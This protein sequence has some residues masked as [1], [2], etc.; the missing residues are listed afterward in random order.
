M[1]RRQDL[2]V[3]FFNFIGYSK[4][5]LRLFRYRQKPVTRII[6]FHDIQDDT[7]KNF[8]DKM[9]VL[10]QCTN[11]VNLKDYLAGRL[12][13]E[14]LNIV[15]TFDDGYKGWIKYAIPV[16]KEMGFPATFFVTSGF[17]GLTKKCESEFVEKNLFRTSKLR[18]ISGGLSQD[19][20]R[21]IIREGFLL[22]GHTLSHC[23]L[24]SISEAEKVKHEIAEDKLKL[25]QISGKKVDYF[26]Y[27]MGGYNNPRLDLVK[28]LEELGF[29]AAVTTVPGFN[30]QGS[31]PYLLHRDLTDVSMPTPVFSARIAG[32]Y[33]AIGFIKKL[34]H[35]D[36]RKLGGYGEN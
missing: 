26:A 12:S 9:V 29:K 35:Y 27:P 36:I 4:V 25:E 34:L 24:E 5:R 21:L 13:F 22:G 19:D 14:K 20:L 30:I 28:S 8:R 31:N 33:D 15:I 32:N 23:D 16:L 7:S 2:L 11:V 10:K 3:R 18:R 6:A 17:V 1:L